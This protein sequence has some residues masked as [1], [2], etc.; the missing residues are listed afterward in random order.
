MTAAEK[1]AK[2]LEVIRSGRSI[3]IRTYTR[4][5]KITKRDLA[6]FE[7]GGHTL[8]KADDKSMYLAS[9]KKF[10]CIDYCAITVE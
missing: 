10:V 5:V 4:A 2:M 3:Y 1:I 8:L 7:A 9:G 6:R